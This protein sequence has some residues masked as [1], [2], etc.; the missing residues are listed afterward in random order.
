MNVDNPNTGR[1]DQGLSM[2]LPRGTEHYAPGHP[3]VRGGNDLIA[4]DIVIETRTHSPRT[5]QCDSPLP[6]PDH[7]LATTPLTH[8]QS[9]FV[10]DPAWSLTSSACLTAWGQLVLAGL[11]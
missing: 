11:G 6:Q 10:R 1:D 2:T 5:A 4:Y 3:P 7:S 8:T 9:R